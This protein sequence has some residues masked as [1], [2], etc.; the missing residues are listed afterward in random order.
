MTIDKQKLFIL[1]KYTIYI[2][3]S[4]NIWV[5][6]QE[7]ALASQEIFATG[8]DLDQ[9][10]QAF[11]ST[12]DTAAWVVLIWLF[13]METAVIPDDKLKGSFKWWLMAVRLVCYG[14]IVYALAGYSA[15]LL[16][17]LSTQPFEVTDVCSLISQQYSYVFDLDEY[18]PV[19]ASICAEFANQSLYLL[20]NTQ[21]IGTAQAMQAATKLAWTD[22]INATAW[23]LVIIMLEVEIFLQL[24]NRLSKHNQPFFNCL[25]IGLYTTLLVCAAYWGM[26]GDFIDFWDAF[27]WLVAFVFIELNIFNWNQETMTDTTLDSATQ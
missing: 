19:T 7:E 20:P 4:F 17:F 21:V 3:L 11:S 25:K 2:L 1:F 10:I 22:V 12:I 6:Y 13:E 16:M 18:P 15:K 9:I 27:L 14:F 8:L 24:R 23:V 26:K 5:F